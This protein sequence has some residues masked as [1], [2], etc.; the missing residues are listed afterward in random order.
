MPHTLLIPEGS[1]GG[2][3]K[4]DAAPYPV[5]PRRI[6]GR[7]QKRHKKRCGLGGRSSFCVSKKD[8]MLSVF[9]A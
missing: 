4:S 7:N 5:D 3:E 1:R 2:A 9:L 6:Q 8:R